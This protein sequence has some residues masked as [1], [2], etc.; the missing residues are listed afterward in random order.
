ME[1]HTTLEAV[2]EAERRSQLEYWKHHVAIEATVETMMLDSQA[3]IIDEMER[4]EI[5]GMLVASVWESWRARGGV[6]DA[7]TC[8]ACTVV[9]RACVH[10][11]PAPVVPAIR[12]VTCRHFGRAVCATLAATLTRGCAVVCVA[13]RL[14]V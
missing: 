4:P 6:A 9:E 8:R 3:A 12:V 11:A 2:D 1:V 7:A 14:Q 5:L 10:H 13:V